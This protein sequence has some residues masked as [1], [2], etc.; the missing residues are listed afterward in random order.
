MPEAVPAVLSGEG[1]VL[2][3]ADVCAIHAAMMV[4]N[5]PLTPTLALSQ[6]GPW[7]YP[8]CD[9]CL[10]NQAEILQPD[11][12]AACGLWGAAGSS[13]QVASCLRLGLRILLAFYCP[14]AQV[15]DGNSGVYGCLSQAGRCTL[16]CT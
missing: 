13:G 1:L 11:A 12:V 16:V 10:A 15:R 2:V 5:P 6:L 4:V 3:D 14:L 7:R 9:S 8:R